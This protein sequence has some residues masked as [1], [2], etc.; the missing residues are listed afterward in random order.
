[1]NLFEAYSALEKIVFREI[2][3]YYNLKFFLAVK[4]SIVQVIFKGLNSTQLLSTMPPDFFFRDSF[5]NPLK[6]MDLFLQKMCLRLYSTFI[7]LILRSKGL[8][9]CSLSVDTFK[10]FYSKLF[11]C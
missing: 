11:K 7:I 1:M 10:N 4:M 3:F 8:T 6:A 2:V 9:L 5:E